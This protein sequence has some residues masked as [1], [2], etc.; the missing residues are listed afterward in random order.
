[1]ETYSALVG[2]LLRALD[3]DHCFIPTDQGR[4]GS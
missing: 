3:I 2:L 1:M 4:G